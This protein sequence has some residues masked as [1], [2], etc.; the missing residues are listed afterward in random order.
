MQILAV[1]Q[2]MPKHTPRFTELPYTQVATRQRE[3]STPTSRVTKPL[4]IPPFGSQEFTKVQPKANLELVLGPR[5]KTSS[6]LR[7][8]LDLTVKILDGLLCDLAPSTEPSLTTCQ[9][10]N[11]EHKPIR[12]GIRAKAPLYR[13]EQTRSHR[14]PLAHP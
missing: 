10:S 13:F 4:P 2:H 12:V 8:Y 14:K 9:A 3:R 1:R 5:P 6:K 7:Q 11:P